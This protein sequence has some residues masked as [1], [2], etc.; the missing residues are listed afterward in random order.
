MNK[1]LLNTLIFAIVCLVSAFVLDIILSSRLR[2][3]KNRIYAAWNQIYTDTT[4]Y[5]LIIAGNSRAYVQYDPIIVDSICHI[6][7]YNL[8]NNASPI[9]RQIIKYKKYCDMHQSP[10]YLI[11]NIDLWTMALHSGVEREQFYPYFFYDRELITKLDE[12][13]YFSFMEKYFPCY[14]YLGQEDVII[15]SLFNDNRQHTFTSLNKG[16]AG[17]DKT[18]DGSSLANTDSVVCLYES[19]A[20]DLFIEFINEVQRDGTQIIFVYAPIYYEVRE[21]MTNEKCMLE[22]YNTIARR[23]DIPILDYNDIPMC[24]DTTYFYNGTHLNKI[25]AELFTTK[26]AFDLD[27]LGFFE[28]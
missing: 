24:Y 12:Y 6:N 15:E 23:F 4:N 17:S 22:M 16:Y 21:K 3:N 25:G 9:S 8:G 2:S 19:D 7:S 5:D 20:I 28:D 18:W 13:E 27:S 14:R 1:Y 26:L 11:Q 10:K